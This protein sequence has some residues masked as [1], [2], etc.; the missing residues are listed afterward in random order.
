MNPAFRAQVYSFPR[1]SGFGSISVLF[2]TA[3]GVKDRQ[4][5]Y[6]VWT[7]AMTRLPS[8]TKKTP[9]SEMKCDH[10]ETYDAWFLRM[11]E[12]ALVEADSPDAVWISHDEVLAESAVRRAELLALIEKG[13]AS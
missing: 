7:T 9:V 3:H 6:I 10:E 4:F 8:M 11:V 13:K 2:R 12:E 5:L 1:F